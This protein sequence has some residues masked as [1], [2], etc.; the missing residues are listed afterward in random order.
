MTRH[1]A[2][3]LVNISMLIS[4][5]TAIENKVAIAVPQAQFAEISLFLDKKSIFE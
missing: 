3:N 1:H 2:R 4:Y 5:L